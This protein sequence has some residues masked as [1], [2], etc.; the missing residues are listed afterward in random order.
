[1]LQI[2]T[3]CK[4]VKR[5][6]FIVNALKGS[7]C[8]YDWQL[9][10]LQLLLNPYQPSTSRRRTQD[11][12]RPSKRRV[13]PQTKPGIPQFSLPVL[14]LKNKVLM[15]VLEFEPILFESY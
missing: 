3:V 5:T 4:N 1:M 8:H 7:Y 9:P 11:E 14:E 13:Q 10:L 12:A 6:T 2:D 15:I